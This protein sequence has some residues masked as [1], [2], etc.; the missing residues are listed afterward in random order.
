MN[1]NN[2]HPVMIT[3]STKNKMIKSKSS[4]PYNNN[5]RKQPK[6]IIHNCPPSLMFLVKFYRF[7]FILFNYQSNKVLIQFYFIYYYPPS[8][9]QNKN[10]GFFPIH[11]RVSYSY[12]ITIMIMMIMIIMKNKIII[13]IMK[14]IIV[15]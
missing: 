5:N 1:D 9:F 4:N 3:M 11:F 7:V 14:I 10:L 6:W 13:I 15:G 2:H 12:R 8:P